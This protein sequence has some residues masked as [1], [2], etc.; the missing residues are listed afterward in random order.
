V[1]SAM[2]RDSH[3]IDALFEVAGNMCVAAASA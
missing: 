3:N 2:H 1:N